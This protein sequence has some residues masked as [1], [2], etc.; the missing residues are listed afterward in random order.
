MRPALAAW[1]RAQYVVR[2]RHLE[3]RRPV[4]GRGNGMS[5]F[6]ENFLS[7][8]DFPALGFHFYPFLNQGGG[9]GP[10][11]NRRGLVRNSEPVK[12]GISTGILCGIV[13]QAK[14][15]AHKMRNGIFHF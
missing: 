11:A 1:A 14:T 15:I 3:P 6:V 8:R 7:R 4:G 9:G 12:I 13:K 10:A 5:E 2:V